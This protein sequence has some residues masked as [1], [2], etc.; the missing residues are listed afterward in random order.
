MI[1]AATLGIHGVFGQARATVHRDGLQSGL[2][3]LF[4]RKIQAVTSKGFELKVVC[5][6]SAFSIQGL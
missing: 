4:S 1:L 6:L 5:F 3:A 2:R